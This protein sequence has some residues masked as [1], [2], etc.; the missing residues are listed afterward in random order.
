MLLLNSN[1]VQQ[2]R[3]LCLTACFYPREDL[4]I[5]GA[6]LVVV[7]FT[8]CDPANIIVFQFLGDSFRDSG[9]K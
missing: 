6:E 3:F 4:I 5:C 1:E 9:L 2:E 8:Y 7:Y